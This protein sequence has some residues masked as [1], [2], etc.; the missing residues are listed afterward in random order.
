MAE[1]HGTGK[2][3]RRKE[4]DMLIIRED[5]QRQEQYGSV[6]LERGLKLETETEAD[7]REEEGGIVSQ[8]SRTLVVSFIGWF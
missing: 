8:I 1:E 4:E 5:S 7:D 6:R 2:C 3:V